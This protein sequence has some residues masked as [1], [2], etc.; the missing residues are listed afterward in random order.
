MLHL[1]EDYEVKF[2]T[3]KPTTIVLA[4]SSSFWKFNLRI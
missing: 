3:K 2:E 1:K 4:C